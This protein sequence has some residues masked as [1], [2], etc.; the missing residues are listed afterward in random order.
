MLPYAAL[1]F[2]LAVISRSTI[3][4]VGGGLLF[5]TAIEIPLSL[6]LPTFGKSFAYFVQFLPV[7]LSQTLNSQ[8]YA[9]ARIAVRYSSIQLTLLF[10]AICIMIYSLVFLWHRAVNLPAS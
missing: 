4:A 5:A 8:N 9:L 10:A 2:M 3:L 1:T 6:V 7:E